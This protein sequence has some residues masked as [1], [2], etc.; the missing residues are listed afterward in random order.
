M[1]DVQDFDVIVLGAGMAG[2]SIAAELAASA[3][4][5]LVEMEDQ[6]G[7]HTTG[8]SAAMF[9]ESYGNPVVR[10]LT[11]ASRSFLL[12]PPRDIADAPL[13]HRRD[14]FIVADA[15]SLD[16]V[17]AM[18]ASTDSEGCVRRVA[19]AE[20]LA[21]CPILRPDRV[22]A[23]L[24]DDSGHDID[25]AGLHQGWLRRLRQRGGT[26]MLDAGPALLQRSDGRW[27]V[28]GRQ[29]RWRAPRVVNATGAWADEV[30][31]QAGVPR[32]GLQPKR[33][34]AVMLPAPEGHDIRNW[35]LVSDIH[36][37]CYFKPDAGQLLLSPANEDDSPPCDAAPEELDIALAAHRFEELTTV[38][39]RRI[40]HRWAGLRTFAPDR[41][42][43]VGYDPAAEGL[44]WFAGQG[45]YG[46][47]MAPAMARAGAALALGRPLP[48]DIAAQGVDAKALSP[49]RL[50]T[51]A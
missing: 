17:A 22:A 31:A 16:A 37:T 23:A 7:R 43:V 40:L 38:P 14:A 51:P 13:M 49:A 12:Q 34:T 41:S 45:G 20:V 29:G 36:E 27:S 11:R 28:Q 32:I 44:F 10:A 19:P 48:P 42:P 21:R 1:Q 30:V 6:P 33:R 47:Q 9:F 39:V 4:V 8:R 25:V 15:A 2:A 3:R 26:L 35:P 46:I 24:M 50:R 5:L 18:E